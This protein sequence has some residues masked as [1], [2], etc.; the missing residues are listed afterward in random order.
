MT[1]FR[2]TTQLRPGWR[3]TLDEHA[4]ELV[5]MERDS[6]LAAAL[7]ADPGWREVYAGEV[8]R[9]FVRRP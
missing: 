5:L 2:E 9:L 1:R 4:V 3:A 8:E 7:A 6:P